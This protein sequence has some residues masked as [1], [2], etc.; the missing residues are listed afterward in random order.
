MSTVHP[1][2]HPVAT[3]EDHAS[4]EASRTLGIAVPTW[5][6]VVMNAILTGVLP[7]TQSARAKS[8]QPR[9]SRE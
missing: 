4:V 9:N 5:S 1:K 8:V 6:F 2:R 3:T 7:L